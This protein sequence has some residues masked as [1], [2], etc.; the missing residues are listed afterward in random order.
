[1]IFRGSIQ[2]CHF[3]RFLLHVI[4]ATQ[5]LTWTDVDENYSTIAY[6]REPI[7]W[8]RFGRSVASRYITC[9]T[10]SRLHYN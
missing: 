8:Q 9:A 4:H 1:M 7:A 3:C 10:R 2:S 5:L 6:S